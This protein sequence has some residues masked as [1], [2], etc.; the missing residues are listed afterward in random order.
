M[1]SDYNIC[2]GWGDRISWSDVN[3]FNSW[4]GNE[5]A[6]FDV[7]G[8]Q[9][10]MPKVGETLKG[11]FNKSIILFEFVEVDQ[12]HNPSDMFFGKVKPVS[13]EMK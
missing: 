11:D 2:S 7:N 6:V 1:V 10:K 5:D 8:H 9:H 12:Q 13:Q 4:E 3:Q